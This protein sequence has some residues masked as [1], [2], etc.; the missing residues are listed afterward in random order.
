MRRK[1]GWPHDSGSRARQT[2]PEPLSV[3]ETARDG[4][5][6]AAQQ[7]SAIATEREYAGDGENI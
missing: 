7:V 3:V 6:Q 1:P 2:C 5:E 4:A